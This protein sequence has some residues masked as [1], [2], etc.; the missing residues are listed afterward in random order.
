MRSPINSLNFGACLTLV[1]RLC[2]ENSR[3]VDIPSD[4]ASDLSD[5]TSL[6]LRNAGETAWVSSLIIF[7]VHGANSCEGAHT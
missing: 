4:N 6:T 1:G 3:L 2:C 5:D 7:F